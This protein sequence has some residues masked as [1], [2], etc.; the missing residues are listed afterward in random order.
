MKTMLALTAV[1][2]LGLATV[3]GCATTG[4]SCGSCCGDGEKVE[5]CGTCG[6]DSKTMAS[7]CCGACSTNK[8]MKDGTKSDKSM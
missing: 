2:M 6:C 4:K 5:A 8:A 1:A 3:G 7:E